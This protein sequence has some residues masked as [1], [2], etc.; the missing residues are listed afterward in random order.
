MKYI[1]I[2]VFC[3]FYWG[4]C[5]LGTG[6]DRKNLLGLRSYPEDVQRIVR[7]RPELSPYL[8]KEKSL[9]AILLSNL[10]LFIVVFSVLGRVF[11]TV[12]GLTSYRAAFF[13]FPRAGR[14]TRPF[15]SL[16]VIDL[17][18][19]RNTKRIR[20]SFL[21]EKAPYQDPQKHIGSFVRG[22]P[23][24]GRCRGHFRRNREHPL[25]SIKKRTAEIIHSAFLLCRFSPSRFRRR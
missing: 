10:L 22:I 12:L 2:L 24:F 7:Q 20:F 3:F 8:P 4:M 14:R 9:P 25:S 17:L 18:W 21:P 1:T 11:K 19:W 23:L 15:L 13:Y 5:V 16:V 6:G